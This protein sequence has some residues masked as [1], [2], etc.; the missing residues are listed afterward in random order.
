[1]AS[2][3]PIAKVSRPIP[4]GFYP[5]RRLYRLLDKA[6]KVPLL[7]ITGPPGCGKTSLIS[8]YVES[9]R[10]SCLWYKIDEADAD[11]STFFYYLG[12]AAVKA[13][14][15]RRKHLP[16]LTP[17][18]LPG[19]LVFS[20]RYFEELSSLLPVPSLLVL[21]D[22]HR[23]QENAVFFETLR[24]GVSRLAPGINAV[25]ISRSDPDPAFARDRANRHMATFGWKDLRLTL[26]E[27]TG[28]VKLQRK[29]K[30]AP[31]RVRDLF[32]R[33]DG[34]AA[35]LV[36]LLERTDTRRVEP[37]TI[38]HQVP[39]EIIDYF[40]SEV[41]RLLDEE[42]RGFLLRTAFLPRMTASMAERLTGMVGAGSFLS[43]MNRHNQF[44]KKN[45]QREP[46]YEYHDLFREFLLERATGVFS[47]EELAEVRNGAASLLEQDGYVEDAAVLFRQ[48]GNWDALARLALSQAR[49]L[50]AQGRYQPLLEWL[51]VLPKQVL[52]DDPW[53]LYWNGV[54]LMPFSPSESRARFEEALHAFDARRE[55]PGVFLSWSGVVASIMTPMENFTPVDDWVSLLPR[56]LEK[57]GGLPAGEIGDEVT[58]SMYGALSFRQ[59]PRTDVELWT[60]RAFSVAQTCTDPRLKFR[61][62]L[63]I[64]T[65]DTTKDTRGAERTLASMMEGLKRPDATPMMRL[66]LDMLFATVSIV[67]GKHERCLQ[68]AT[69]GLA[70]AENMGVH[71]ADS[72]LE[73]YGAIA[74][75]K[76]HDF[77]TADRFLD[78]MKAALGTT[79]PLPSGLFHCI[80][81]C[82]ALHRSDLVKASFH[83]KECLRLWEESGFTTH[84]P[85]AHILAA[86][87]YHALREDGEA[88]R[89]LAKALRIG[90]ETGIPIGVWLS[91]MT[92]AY[93]HLERK[94]DALAITPL[95]KGLQIGRE[96]GIVGT[97]LWLPDMFERVA[98][99]ALEEGIEIEYVRDFIQRHRI[100]PDP[101]NPY[102]AKWPWPVKV[103][104]LG[105]FGLFAD[106]H[107][108]EFG[109]K[110]QRRPLSL[111]KALIAIG[112]RDVSEARITELLW[113]DAD[114][115]LAHQ[116][117]SVALNR[118]RKIL[119]KEEALTLKEGRLSLSNRYCWV[120]VWAFER[121]TAQA[122]KARKEGKEM[123]AIRILEKGL[124]IYRGSFLQSEEA[125]WAISRREKLRSGFLGIVEHLGRYYEKLE[126][127]DEAVSCYEKGLKVDEVAEELYRCLMICHIRRGREVEA[128][129]I[130]RR[131]RE[132]LSSVLGVGP[133]TETRSIAA[134]LDRSTT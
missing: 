52:D 107:P 61:L 56:L 76:L 112:G 78:R 39:T 15:R 131:C 55:A 127:W 103:Y 14:P 5:R 115:D 58:C 26:E 17:E 132:M 94:D 134:S 51:R 18:R 117:F 109:R 116:S 98:V 33:T 31:E 68:V 53:L 66:M 105:R 123:E 113:P 121:S 74:A 46:V 95:K 4:S 44:T 36:L 29:E 6:R 122:E 69:D 70:F 43:E 10:L 41:F 85:S 35:G 2:F 72:Y 73:A 81:A 25:F 92:E 30:V 67:S 34:W 65:T 40:G 128:L 89:H 130:Y 13:T 110:A 22:C 82:D 20:Q 104:T 96:N 119:G 9:R 57:Y 45:L 124:S 42:R 108:V 71:I 54:C 8:S 11:L 106:D 59:Y 86:H 99:K 21:D 7:W 24:E 48:S 118:L 1:M 126:R 23:L 37:R 32:D 16:L 101:A 120:D 102:P 133:S 129:S 49:S 27:A 50:V 47:G 93:F 79:K 90:S 77:E 100:V 75:M 87:V 28:I 19:R 64:W 84:I 91:Y 63:A 97:T 111:L 88:D 125:D 62:A 3:P 12:L 83:S 60:P 38:G 114:G 80:T